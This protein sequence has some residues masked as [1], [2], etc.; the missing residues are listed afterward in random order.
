MIDSA[1]DA[2]ADWYDGVLEAGSLLHDIAMPALLNFVGHVGG[3]HICDLACGQGIVARRLARLGARVDGIDLSQRLLDIAMRYEAEQPLGIA[4][5]QGDA[6]HL[7]AV[8]DGCYHGVICVMALMDI[9]DLGAACHT[10]SR[11]LKRDGRFIF[12]ITHP[13]FQTPSSSWVT[14][15][16]GIRARTVTNYTREGFWRSD[17]LEGVR[18]KVG[19][20][21]RTL[22]TYVHALSEAGLVIERLEEPLP[23][24]DI[25]EHTGV[26]SVLVARCR[27]VSLEMEQQDA[28]PAAHATPGGTTVQPLRGHVAM[29]TGAGRGI[30][31]ASALSLAG[32][33]ASVVITARTRAELDAVG[34]EIVAMGGSSLVH[35]ADVTDEAAVAALFDATLA[36]HGRLDLLVNNAG[37][38]RRANIESVPLADW[39]YIFEVNATS[40]FLC[41]RAAIAP[42]RAAGGG[43]IINVTSMAAKRGSATRGSYSAAKFSVHGLSESLAAEV[44]QDGIHVMCVCPGAVAT[45]LRARSVPGEDQSTLLTPEDVADA[46]LFVATRHPRVVLP[47]ICLWPRA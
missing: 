5:Q 32:A 12:V 17:N 19:A 29:V 36:W 47:E 14:D 15:T 42:M 33:G 40:T 46:V 45:A 23:A 7:D 21:H 4:Y 18:G 2:I 38:N 6:Q 28:I 25:A 39:R 26:P 10:I 20:Y 43:R 44:L 1:Y 9:P 13:C 16:S 3:V 37:D 22:S 30:G 11:I 8:P 41:S 24:G 35:E 31:R 27:K 34:N